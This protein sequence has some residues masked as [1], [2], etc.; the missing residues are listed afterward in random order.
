MEIFSRLERIEESQR[1]QSLLGIA[2]GGVG[3]VGP[4]NELRQLGLPFGRDAEF[5]EFLEKLPQHRLKLTALLATFVE[6]ALGRSVN[7][8]LQAI[9]VPDVWSLY[10]RDGK[11]NKVSFQ[12]TG[13]SECMLGE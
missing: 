8:M 6:K 12:D 7:N 13:L 10:S 1:R 4:V 11:R 9:C 5:R 2:A 3:R